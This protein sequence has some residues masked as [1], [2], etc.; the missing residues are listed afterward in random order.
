MSALVRDN[1]GTHTRFLQSLLSAATKT[2]FF[3]TE[4]CWYVREQGFPSLPNIQ[5]PASW[6]IMQKGDDYYT[7][8]SLV[9]VR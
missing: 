7:P 1:I 2:K 4:I 6:Q 9:G 8:L 3:Q 5:K